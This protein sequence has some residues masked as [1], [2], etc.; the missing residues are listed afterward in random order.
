[1]SAC[2]Q[3]LLNHVLEEGTGCPAALAILYTEI[4]ARMGLPLHIHSLDQ[5]TYFVVWPQGS[6]RPCLDGQA[7]LFDPYSAGCPFLAREVGRWAALLVLQAASALEQMVE[8]VLGYNWMARLC[9]LTPTP[10]AARFWLA[11]WGLLSPC[12]R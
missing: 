11:R 8:G 6:L 10:R 7:V 12:L 1:M 2:R 4:C 3:A 9:C 5:G